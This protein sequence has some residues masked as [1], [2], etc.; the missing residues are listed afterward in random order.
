M[1]PMEAAVAAMD[2]PW[3][4]GTHDCCASACSAFA[5]LRGVDPMAPLRGRY[6]DVNGAARLIE[7]MGGWQEMAEDLASRA[8]LTRCESRPGVLGLATKGQ[9]LGFSLVFC[10]GPGLWAGKTVRGMTLLTEVERAWA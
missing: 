2:H 9:L 10:V 1:T 4:W 5:A 6:A 7:E 8:G 3:R